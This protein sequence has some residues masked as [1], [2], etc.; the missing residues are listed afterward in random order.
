MNYGI[1]C[2]KD[3]GESRAVNIAALE[4]FLKEQNHSVFVVTVPSSLKVDKTFVLNTSLELLDKS[5]QGECL[6]AGFVLKLEEDQLD[7]DL[8][9][10]WTAV[11][12]NKREL[13]RKILN[14]P[15]AEI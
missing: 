5:R 6:D 11:Y 2:T 7:Y 9:E 3:V 8:Y 10:G 15:P 14:S 4:T 1:F 12:R 13:I